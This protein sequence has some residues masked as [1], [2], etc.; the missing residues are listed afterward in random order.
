[1]TDP[2]IVSGGVGDGTRLAWLGEEP[3]I[4]AVIWATVD[5]ERALG[6]LGLD[7]ARADSAAD[8]PLLGARV[9]L[10]DGP[11]VSGPNAPRLVGAPPPIAI[12]E[13]STEGRLAAAVA[14]NDEGPV[15]HYLVAA[16]SLDEVRR[17]AVEAGVALSR[18]ERGPFG[19]SMLLV[20]GPIGGR[21]VVLVDPP[22]VPSPP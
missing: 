8:D 7:P 5:L 17:R 10:V 14:R 12:A 4:L 6:G 13:P 1:M 11:P 3:V 15:G 21:L 20:G 9:V 16:A 2:Q 18:E 19:P 22:A